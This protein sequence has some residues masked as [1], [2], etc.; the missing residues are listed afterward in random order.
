MNNV[1]ATGDCFMN[2]A[3][4][5]LEIRT[6]HDLT[7]VH[8]VVTGTGGPVEGVE[9]SHAF[10]IENIGDLKVAIDPSKSLH[11]PTILPLDLYRAIGNV[12]KEIHYDRF[13]ARRMLLVHEHYGAWNES[14]QTDADL[15][16]AEG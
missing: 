6:Q 13:E 12:R 2:A 11:E 14:L 10:V 3:K 9:F 15:A 7:L 5:V 4:Y 16:C 1:K 8:C